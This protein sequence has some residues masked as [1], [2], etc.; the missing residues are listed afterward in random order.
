MNKGDCFILCTPNKIWIYIG[1]YS[2]SCE[3]YKAIH[4]A[5]NIREQDYQNTETEVEIQHVKPTSAQDI[6]EAFFQALG[7]GSRAE[8]AEPPEIDDDDEMEI[9]KE[10]VTRPT[11]IRIAHSC[12]QSAIVRYKGKLPYNA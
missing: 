10:K 7:G 8:I 12:T 1:K 9:L 2:K 11:S 4:A 5:S 6:V 3:R